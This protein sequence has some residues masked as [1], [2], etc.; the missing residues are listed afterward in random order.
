VAM[1]LFNLSSIDSF[2][3]LSIEFMFIREQTIN[4]HEL[5]HVSR[6]AAPGV[7]DMLI[8]SICLFCTLSE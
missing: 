5:R 1:V 4:N 2:L 6:A 8:N 7:N 3:Y